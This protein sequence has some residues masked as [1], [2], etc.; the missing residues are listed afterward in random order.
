MAWGWIGSKLALRIYALKKKSTALESI[1][2]KNLSSLDKYIYVC[3][4]I[5]IYILE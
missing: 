2:V 3:I 1:L 5:C 4:Y